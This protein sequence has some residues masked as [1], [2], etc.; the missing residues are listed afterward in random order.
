MIQNLLLASLILLCILLIISIFKT[1]F[2]E[3][4]DDY[5]G[6]KILSPRYSTDGIK[7]YAHISIV[8]EKKYKYFINFPLL[9]RFYSDYKFKT[10]AKIY[11]STQ[12]ME[13]QLIMN[14]TIEY[15][16]K[17]NE[18]ILYI[19][20]VILEKLLIEIELEIDNGSPI[21][22]FEIMQNNLFPLN[23]ELKLELNFPD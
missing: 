13:K 11:Y 9:F 1:P 20:N 8:V 3:S 2:I 17:T 7:K 6:F 22:S 4:I 16:S 12:G 19:T 18:H 15:S 21:I 23:N 14:K 5:C 10:N